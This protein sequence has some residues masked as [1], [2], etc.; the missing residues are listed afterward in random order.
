[1]LERQ[2]RKPGQPCSNTATCPVTGT[3]TNKKGHP[4]GTFTG[5]LTI[6]QFAVQNGQVVA[7]GTLSGTAID[8]EGKVISTIT[9]R[10]VTVPASI[11]PT[12]NVLSLTLGPLDLNLLGLMIHLNQV[13]LTITANPAGGLLG[14]LLCSLAGTPPTALQTIVNLLNQILALL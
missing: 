3:V 8:N 13:V 11:D 5:T 4:T 1:M 10:A 12:C 2:L 6:T 14:S 9:N 7:L